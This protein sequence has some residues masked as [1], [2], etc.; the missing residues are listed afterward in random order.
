MS[1]SQLE[2][3][4]DRWEDARRAGREIPLDELCR[5]A[6]HLLPE[7]RAYIS[8]LEFVD[9][10]FGNSNSH[11]KPNN[12]GSIVPCPLDETAAPEVVG[13]YVLRERIGSGGHA[14]V[15]KAIDPQLERDVAV[16]FPQ[17]SVTAGRDPC[18]RFR[19]EARRL[20]RLK[21]PGIVQ[22]HDAGEEAGM[23][24]I[25]TDLIDGSSFDKYARN[26][27]LNIQQCVTIVKKVAEALQA[28]HSRGIIHRDIKGSNIFVDSEGTPH[29]GDFGIAIS[30]DT[31]RD[32][33]NPASCTVAHA[34]PEQNV[35]SRIPLSHTTDVFGLGVVL[36]KLL[37]DH[38]PFGEQGVFGLLNETGQMPQRPGAIKPNVPAVL[39]RVCLRALAWDPKDR[40]P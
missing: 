14:H 16:K 33:I 27:R 35:C 36:Y 24:Y 25:V 30:S 32:S 21:H 29:V 19:S 18:A 31:D 37:T 20:A 11:S 5:D 28:A 26:N 8:D 10:R 15:F 4:V 40:F 3:L 9:A 38:L 22:V 23:P 1:D 34:A 7:V 13:R 2:E 39:D 17:G 12:T 6:P